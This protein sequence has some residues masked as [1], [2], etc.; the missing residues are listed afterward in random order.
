MFR[1]YRAIAETRLAFSPEFREP[2]KQHTGTEART[3]SAE[4]PIC[5]K[6]RRIQS[7]VQE[8]RL[9]VQIIHIP[10]TDSGT[11]KQGSARGRYNEAGRLCNV[12]LPI[13]VCVW[14]GSGDG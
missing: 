11:N 12:S 1:F 7:Q 6:Q 13:A 14:G 4:K 3:M 9:A 5:S 8:G 10:D 2:H